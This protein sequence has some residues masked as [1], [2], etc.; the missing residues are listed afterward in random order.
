METH[1]IIG[2]TGFVGSFLAQAYPGCAL[3]H[4][5]NIEEIQGRSFRRVICA[6]ISAVKWV[7]NKEP[8]KDRQGIQRL[9]NCLETLSAE[10]FIHISTTDVFADTRGADE[11]TPILSEGLHAYGLHRYQ[12]ENFIREK[13][14]SHLIMRFPTL[15][16]P[17][18]RKNV[19]FD[20]LNDNCLEQIPRR[21][22]LQWYDIRRMPSDIEK[23]AGLS[24]VHIA[25]EPLLIQTI[26]ERAFPQKMGAGHDKP[27]AHYDMR[28]LY[29]ERFGGQEGYIQTADDVMRNICRFAEEERAKKRKLA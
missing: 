1:A 7:A 9:Q 3:F 12:F 19:L 27:S 20:L 29:A 16:G 14:S 28:T 17:G 2:S 15:F 26:I 18:L 11:N 10:S 13:F 8:E 23:A 4:S 21:A 6:G 5:K 25:T 22:V 24:L